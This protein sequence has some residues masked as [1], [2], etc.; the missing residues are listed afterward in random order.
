MFSSHEEGINT[1]V[2]LTLFPTRSYSD[3]ESQQAEASESPLLV[4]LV[5]QLL[6]G[7][8]RLRVLLQVL[9]SPIA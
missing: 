5:L 3:A 2:A 6:Q 9:R 1:S 8:Q 4:H 7:Q